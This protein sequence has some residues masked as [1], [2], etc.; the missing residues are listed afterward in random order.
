MQ[1][2]PLFLCLVSTEIVS[3]HR[4]RGNAERNKE[5]RKERRTMI[6]QS[7]GNL[8]DQYS[9]RIHC[10]SSVRSKACTNR[11]TLLTISHHTIKAV[12]SGI[13][14]IFKASVTLIT[15]R[16]AHVKGIKGKGVHRIFLWSVNNRTAR[17][18]HTPSMFGEGGVCAS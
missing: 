1:S 12:A 18:I 9:M 6:H 4:G 16:R 15:T 5:E 7:G 8:D 2:H 17:Q 14:A 10:V 11:R 13:E 3:D